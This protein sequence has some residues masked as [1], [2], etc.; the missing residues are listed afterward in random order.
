MEKKVARILL[1]AL[2][3]LFSRSGQTDMALPCLGIPFMKKPPR[4]D[5]KIEEQEW[6]QASRMIGFV[7]QHN[8]E[9]TAREGI[10]WVG[11]DRENLY[12]AMKTEVAPDGQLLTRAVPDGQRDIVAAC[13][14][15]SVELVIHPHLGKTSGDT[16]YFHIICNDRTAM[17]DRSID[18]ANPQ[19]PVNTA[20]RLKNWTFARSLIEGF[21]HVEIAIPFS[22]IGAS[23]EDLNHV[24]GLR[25]CRNWQRPWDQSRW[26]N[27]N[28]AYED[29]PTMPRVSFSDRYP[30]VQLTKLQSEG[31]PQIELSVLA[32]ETLPVKVFIS[33]VW[34]YNPP[35]EKVWEQ[36]IAAGTKETFLLQPPHGGPEGAHHTIIRVTSPDGREVYYCR[37]FR[38]HLEKPEE[39]WTLTREEKKAVGLQY[40]IY[41][42]YNRMK[43]RVDISGLAAREEVT[44]AIVTLSRQGE[45]KPLV[46]CPMTFKGTEAEVITE[47]PALGE[48]NYEVAVTLQ[49]GKNVPAE[50]VVG[51]YERKVFPWEHNKLG[52]SERVIPPFEPIQIKG[53]TLSTVLRQH[54]L[55]GNG[56]WNQVYSLEQ[57][58]LAAPMSWRVTDK[59]Q[60][61]KVT[62]GKLTLLSQKPWQVVTAGSFSAGPLNAEVKTEW[63]YDGLAKITLA[64]K[65]SRQS[66]IDGLSLEIP[67][68]D[69]LVRYLHTCGDGIRHNYA[70]QTPAGEGLI[71]NSNQANKINIVG[72]FYPYLWLGGGERGL[73]WFADTDYDWSLDEKKPALELFRQGQV[74]TLRVNFITKDTPLDRERRIVFG[75]Q[76]TPAKPMPEVPVNWRRW[77]CRYYETPKTQPFTILGASYYYGCLS[78]DFYP[79]KKDFSIYEAF[80]RA[81][82]TGTFD[83]AFV[84][85]W[86]EKYKEFVQPGTDRWTFFV[87]H[88][89]SGMSTAA[90]SLRSRGWLLTPY[91]NPRGMG[92]HMEEWPTFQ[93]EWIQFPYFQR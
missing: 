32:T 20:W 4:L 79:L 91:T 81:R 39:C 89:N 61:L 14:D 88:I 72:P 64:L 77:L 41:P 43:V 1:T 71:W 6:A 28:T 45:K 25:V 17:Y 83:K 40:K 52:L 19:N 16:R 48:G 76:A 27:A 23:Q 24:W 36:T 86:L 22:E 42:Y 29:I 67:L 47:T 93:D 50:P 55:N 31:K 33:D 57:P 10:F 82:D 56:L 8:L 49:G 80:S 66:T 78:C 65:P 26:E 3:F 59:G 92:F 70:G 12:L 2:L 35:A 30:V 51:L 46:S 13:Y 58:L 37:E 75:L 62:P 74:L 87:N 60:V 38:W 90:G 73:A 15:D 18:P 84:E 69:A 9:L 21:W 7:S 53:Q 68:R 34:S 63:D 11:V 44:G 85:K 5:G 54:Q